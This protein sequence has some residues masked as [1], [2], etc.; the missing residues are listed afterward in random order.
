MREASHK[1][2]SNSAPAPDTFPLRDPLKSREG[3]P[4]VRLAAM[5]RRDVPEGDKLQEAG[6]P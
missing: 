6:P 5:H 4:I 1:A 2:W 3:E